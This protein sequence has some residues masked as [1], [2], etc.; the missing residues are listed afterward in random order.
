MVGVRKGLLG[1]PPR[2]KERGGSA[3]SL[4]ER[5]PQVPPSHRPNISSTPARLQ[6]GQFYLTEYTVRH[7]STGSCMGQI[8]ATC[9]LG[10]K[11]Q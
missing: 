1:D 11:K 7:N 4:Q 5:L 2:L 6:T 3:A 10:E 8:V 9:F